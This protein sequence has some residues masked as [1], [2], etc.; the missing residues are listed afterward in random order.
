MYTLWIRNTND[1]TF[2]EMCIYND[3]S[4]FEEFKIISASLTLEEGSA[5][6]LDLKVP[7]TNVGYEY[8][9]I[10]ATEIKIV[11]NGAVYWIGRLLSS[12]EDWDANLALKFEGSYNYLMD[13]V[14]LQNTL[15]CYPTEWLKFVLDTHNASSAANTE[16]WK[17]IQLGYVDT[18]IDTGAQTDFYS[19]Y[20]TALDLTNNV[21][22]GWSMHP[23]FTYTL[24]NHFIYT[25]RVT[26]PEHPTDI[27]INYDGTT[28]TP[29]DPDSVPKF[30]NLEINIYKNYLTYG[31]RTPT[32]TFGE[33]LEDY[34][35][36]NSV[37]ELATV[38]VPKGGAYDDEE[39]AIIVAS[40]TTD[41]PLE[42]SAP[43]EGLDYYCTV[44]HA[45]NHSEYVVTNDTA[46]L[47]RFGVVCKVVEFNDCTDPA[48]LLVLAQNYLQNQK[49][50]GTNITIK[51]IDAS[52]LGLDVEQVKI[53]VGVKCYSE[54][55]E[56]DYTYP[57]TGITEDLLDPSAT[58]FTLGIKD[59][60]Y[61]SDA[62]RRADD[63]L[64]KLIIKNRQRENVLRSNADK[65]IKDAFSNREIWEPSTLYE[66]FTNEIETGIEQAESVATGDAKRDAM[67]LLNIFDNELSNNK[68]YVFFRK[69][70]ETGETEEHIYEICISDTY[71]YTSQNASLWRWNKSGLYFITGGWTDDNRQ[72]GYGDDSDRLR[73]AITYDGQIVADRITAGRLDAG[74]IR[75]GYLCSQDFDPADY[76]H[77][78]DSASFVLDVEHGTILA[79]TGALIF[80]CT[81]ELDGS[82]GN[83]KGGQT[84]FVYLS[85]LTTGERTNGKGYMEVSGQEGN[86][87]LF[88]LGSNFGVDA[89]GRVFMREGI[90]GATGGIWNLR[91]FN[92]EFVNFQWVASS[93]SGVVKLQYKLTLNT[94]GYRP[95]GCQVKPADYYDTSKEQFICRWRLARYGSNNSLIFLSSLFNMSPDAGNGEYRYDWQDTNVTYTGT[96]EQA[97][98][99]YADI[100]YRGSMF[101][102]YYILDDSAQSP[103]YTQDGH[104]FHLIQGGLIKITGTTNDNPQY[105][106]WSDGRYV[107]NVGQRTDAVH[108]GSGYIYNGNIG[109]NSSFSLSAINRT[110][111]LAVPNGS[112]SNTTTRDDWR[113]T[114]GS[115]FGVTDDGTLHCAGAYLRNAIVDSSISASYVNT[116]NVGGV[117]INSTQDLDGSTITYTINVESD[118]TSAVYYA[119]PAWLQVYVTAGKTY[120]SNTQEED[121]IDPVTV[122]GHQYIPQTA[123]YDDIEF[124]IEVAAEFVYN[125]DVS[126]HETARVYENSF[127][128]SKNT[129][130]Y[131]DKY[132]VQ[133]FSMG[134]AH[135]WA[136]PPSSAWSFHCFN[137]EVHMG[138]EKI[139]STPTWQ[140]TSWAQETYAARMG[141]DHSFSGQM[142]VVKGIANE[143]RTVMDVGSR[144]LVSNSRWLG[145]PNKI[146]GRSYINAMHYHEAISGLSSR[147]YKNSIVSLPDIYDKL[148][149]DLRPVSFFYNKA[150]R[151]VRHTGFI[152]EEVGD[153]MTK[154]G[155]SPVDFG[156]YSPNIGG[157]GGELCY[158]DFIALNTRQIQKLKERIRE[159]EERLDEVERNENSSNT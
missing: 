26:D 9:E 84:N 45:N 138:N 96:A 52:L 50:I 4:T 101:P 75:A 53:G 41:D 15:N 103:D 139:D 35:K 117:K 102:V 123:F 148:F 119:G 154:N 12:S 116:N 37:T 147:V 107:P 68:G 72:S 65:D 120:D 6:S 61:M 93:T 136:T 69:R 137:V 97:A 112:G 60:S 134:D 33:N 20:E 44:W 159:L 11:K 98:E 114:V 83:R 70:Q 31:D 158:M 106:S 46:M 58:N 7:I 89:Y 91:F 85:N 99:Y 80:N 156:A 21:I 22:E 49:W 32:I 14:V 111:T 110:A 153:A 124:H 133:E 126:V 152:M 74:I 113:L 142:T 29:A 79:K 108:V 55:H 8:F 25:D 141:K 5:G 28:G 130:T 63:E 105:T 118:W 122:S 132:V 151:H 155:I 127:T 43:I 100:F 30:W 104:G 81:T 157:A 86:E 95:M 16:Y 87:W 67:K 27:R 39:K 48:E 36:E 77:P 18:S 57:C 150:E 115:K 62:S 38:I 13:T 76:D 10:L 140:M 131:M 59:N 88:I 40:L 143:P 3:E 42:G 109:T 64:K 82:L 146:W 90:I 2:E 47:N 19:D 17:V 71:D 24:A 92:S 145:G 144:D 129:Q 125:S 128:F 121:P 56:L 1:S 94:T 23:V 34:T 73:I 66:Y 135:G 149:D 54:P 78:W 51:A